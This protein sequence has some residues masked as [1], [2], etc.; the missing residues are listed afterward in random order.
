M[1]N[2]AFFLNQPNLKEKD[3]SEL[4][5]KSYRLGD[6]EYEF[7]LVSYLIEQRNNGIQ[8][9]LLS[10]YNGKVPH[11]KFFYVN[12]LEQTYRKDEIR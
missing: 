11:H 4:L 8:S 9:Y 7:L 1:T 2:I 3:L 6:S 10:N 12:N 5:T